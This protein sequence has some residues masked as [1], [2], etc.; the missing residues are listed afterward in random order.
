MLDIKY[1]RENTDLI[2]KTCQQKNSAADIDKLLELDKERRNLLQ[3][4][5]EI[6]AKKNQASKEIV[7][8]QKEEKQ[9]AIEAMQAL[10]EEEKSMQEDLKKAEEE[11]LKLMLLVPQPTR[12]DTPEGKDDT[13]NQEMY[14]WGEIP[15]FD[16]EIKDHIALGNSLDII[17][18]PRAAKIAGSRNYF[19]KGDGAL[20]EHAV[21]QYTIN[22]LVAKGFTLFNPPQIVNYEPMMGTSYFPGGE[23]QAYAVGV[24]KVRGEAIES[25][26]KYLIGTSEV[27]VAAYHSDEI[28]N[29]EELPKLYAGFSSC[30]RRE[31]GSYGKDTQGLYRVHQFLKVEQVILCKNDEDESRKMHELLRKN[32]EEVL[33]DLKLP[34]RV[35][36]VCTGDI[37]QGQHYKN[38]I[39]TWMPSRN[40]YG[41][42]HSCSTFLEFQARRLNIRYRD[43]EGKI[44]FVH[45]LNNTA[46]ATPRV[47]IS[48]LEIYQNSDGTVNI[49][50]A[51]QPYMGGKEKIEVKA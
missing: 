34:Y 41:E 5:E 25:D 47:L 6:K 32:A 16:F 2:K 12:A 13:E 7:T 35:V 43:K 51:L 40:N 29:E 42:T 24:E 50:E 48:I 8:L 28:L 10:G 14:T 36:A 39:E 46:I 3:K 30:Y 38:D 31:A 44:N 37:G 21:L 27:P 9:R 33:Q 1:I 22:K 17:D 15:N 4:T 18:M 20:L 23:E 11:F 45:T 26:K 19:L 49:P